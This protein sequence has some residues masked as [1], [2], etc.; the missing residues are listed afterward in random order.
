MFQEAE[1]WEGPPSF[2]D[3]H[4]MSRKFS[5]AVFWKEDRAKL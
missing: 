2:E 5:M 4:S 1:F 3:K